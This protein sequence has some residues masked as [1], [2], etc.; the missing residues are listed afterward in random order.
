MKKSTFL[1]GAIGMIGAA[2]IGAGPADVPVTFNAPRV[3]DSKP[4]STPSDN[5]P[6]SEANRL[7]GVVHRLGQS[8]GSPTFSRA[9]YYTK[10]GKRPHRWACS[11]KGKTNWIKR[12]RNLR[13][14]HK[15]N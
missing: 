7:T 3:A 10:P 8:L 1:A 5:Q 9:G 2:M 4:V 6:V 14:K 13:R 15:R 11:G 12:G